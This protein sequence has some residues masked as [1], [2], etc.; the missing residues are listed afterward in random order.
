MA[1]KKIAL[2]L[3]AGAW[4]VMLVQSPA[5]AQQ[6]KAG[7]QKAEVS[8]QTRRNARVPARPR[9]RL[10]V[11]RRSYLDAGTEVYP[12]SMGYTD[13]VMPPG[14]SAFSNFDPTG[15]S[16]YPLP[17]AFEFRSYHTPGGGY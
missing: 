17:T 9:S 2:L 13:Y 4:A 10:T 14:Y 5:T 15:A 8:A 6:Q 11:T 3:T 7:Y 1:L 12:G 16:R